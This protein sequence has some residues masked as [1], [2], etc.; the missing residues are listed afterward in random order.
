MGMGRWVC[1]PSSD[2]QKG[3]RTWTIPEQ[4]GWYGGWRGREECT[5]DNKGRQW[6]GQSANSEQQ[7]Q[8]H[9]SKQRLSVCTVQCM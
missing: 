7:M 5:C 6:T 3:R 2:G 9:H 1:R 4:S 8:R